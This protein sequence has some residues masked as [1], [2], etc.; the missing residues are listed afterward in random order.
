LDIPDHVRGNHRSI[1]IFPIRE[2]ACLSADRENRGAHPEDAASRKTAAKEKGHPDR[3]REALVG[4][5]Q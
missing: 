5:G 4:G 2:N 1:L 3:C